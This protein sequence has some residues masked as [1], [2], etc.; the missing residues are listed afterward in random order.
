MYVKVEVRLGMYLEVPK[1]WQPL[2][3]LKSDNSLSYLGLYRSMQFK[4]C[5]RL[6]VYQLGTDISQIGQVDLSHGVK[7]HFESVVT[8]KDVTGAQVCLRNRVFPLFGL[9]RIRH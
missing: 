1:I 8:W 6:H 9:A 2:A 7:V 3:Q 5:S 4:H